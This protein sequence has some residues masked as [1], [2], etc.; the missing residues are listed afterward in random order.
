MQRKNK[1]QKNCFCFKII[2]QYITC[3]FGNFLPFPFFIDI[4]YTND[5][6]SLIFKC[7]VI[8]ILDIMRYQKRIPL[9]QRVS[10]LVLCNFCTKITFDF[11]CFI[12]CICFFFFFLVLTCKCLCKQTRICRNNHRILILEEKELKSIDLK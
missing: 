10:L 11:Y 7:R 3:R 4:L 2:N 9:W 5:F 8:A 1:K 6:Y 12:A